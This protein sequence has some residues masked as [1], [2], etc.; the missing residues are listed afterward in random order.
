MGLVIGLDLGSR[1]LGVVITHD[2]L[3]LRAVVAI[4]VIVDPTDLG[5]AVAI[6]DA[7]LELHQPS[8]AV[9]EHARFFVPS[10]ASPQKI[11]AMA[12]AHGVCERLH[13][14]LSVALAARA[15]QTETIPRASWAHRVVPHTQGGITDL[16][17]R[18][19]IEGH[20][21]EG[22]EEIA[23]GQDTIDAAG[24]IFGLLMP[25]P[26]R[27]QRYRCRNRPRKTP[28]RSREERAERR[29]MTH[30]MA[31]RKRR[32]TADR[33]SS[34]VCNCG[35]DGQPKT[36]KGRHKGTCPIAPTPKLRGLTT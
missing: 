24:V 9:I 19:A 16:M 20:V 12:E 17:A 23:R 27:R 22:W 26:R 15:V 30:R 33:L 34:A 7:L 29:R 6:V 5:P 11:Q 8:L 10:G 31:A 28:E 4:T 32:G 21:I 18:T 14:R 25:K 2:A 13:E 36:T 35:P 3:P 1:R